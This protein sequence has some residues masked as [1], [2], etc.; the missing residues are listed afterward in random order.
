MIRITITKTSAKRITAVEVKGHAGYAEHGQDIVCAAVSAITIGT[1]NSVKKLL[2]IN[3]QATT[4]EA[5]GLLQWIV[6]QLPEE[7]IDQQ[8]Q[9]LMWSMT[10]TLLMIEQEYDKFIKIKIELV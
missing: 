7:M 5:T 4:D 9:L 8:L 3:L 2:A 6:P 1:V 10:E